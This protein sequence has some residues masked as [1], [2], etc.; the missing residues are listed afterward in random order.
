MRYTLVGELPRHLYIWVDSA[1][2]HQESHG[3]IPAVWYG[4]VSYPGRSWGATV[5]LENGAVYRNIP[6][7]AL[8]FSDWP[9]PEW[10]P[11]D[12]QTW[13][14]YG[15]GFTA[16]EYSYLADLRC[17][18]L[19]NGRQHLGR[20]LF[21]VAPVDDGFSAYPEQAKE[22]M[23]IELDNGR[24]TVQPTNHVLFQDKSFTTG[25]WDVPTGLKRQTDIF[26]A[27]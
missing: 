7:H 12:A 24:L 23:F 15:Y 8:G 14:C 21:T 6:S 20:Y 26:R 19:A 2:T 22:F 10:A 1:Y 16:L 3:F 13:D 5:L 17:M 25:G 9:E 4:L 11:Q 18:A 27:E